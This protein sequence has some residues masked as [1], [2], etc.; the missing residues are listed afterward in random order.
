MSKGEGRSRKKCLAYVAAFLV[1]QTAIILVFALTVM[2]IKSP[3]VRFNAMVVESFSSNNNTATSINMRLLAQLTIKNTNFGHFKYD[4][5]T[6][7]V[8]YNGVPLGEAL[9]PRGRT[10]ARK[11]QRFNINVDVSTDTLSDTN[12][13]NDINSGILRLSSQAKLNGKVHLMKIIKKKKSG[14]MNCD[15]TVNLGNRQVENLRCN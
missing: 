7:V 2:K 12:L 14:Q 15:W 4:N 8:F 9:I 6:L 10:K 3:K 1:F 5:A 13:G 11:T